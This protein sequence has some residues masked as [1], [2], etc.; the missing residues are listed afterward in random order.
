MESKFIY[1]MR[2][3]QFVICVVLEFGDNIAISRF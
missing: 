2:T 1:I 3:A